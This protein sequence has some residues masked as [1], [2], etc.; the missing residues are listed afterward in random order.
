[1]IKYKNECEAEIRLRLNNY[2]DMLRVQDVADILGVVKECARRRIEKGDIKSVTIISACVVAK[3]WLIEYLDAG[4][5]VRER[6]QN[7]QTK[8]DKIVE[9]CQQPQSRQEIQDH[10]GYSTLKYVRKVL[11]GLITEGRLAYTEKP[12]HRN[13][14]HL[15]TL[16]KG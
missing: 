13:Q 1:V 14:K 8:R 10:F 4:H 7:F 16:K 3:D 2:G 5:S 15:T 11:T 12:H 6:A 9:Y